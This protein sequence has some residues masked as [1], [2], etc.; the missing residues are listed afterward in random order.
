LI[1]KLTNDK[2]RLAIELIKYDHTLEP[3]MAFVFGTVVFDI[4]ILNNLYYSL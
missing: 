4:Y 3:A 2:A 1:K